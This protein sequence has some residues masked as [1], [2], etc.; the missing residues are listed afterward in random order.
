MLMVTQ[1][2]DSVSLKIIL[3][4][5]NPQIQ[6]D[7]CGLIAFSEPDI[8]LFRSTNPRPQNLHR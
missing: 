8:G 5:R 1:V 3:T 7:V 2:K 4:Y 6:I